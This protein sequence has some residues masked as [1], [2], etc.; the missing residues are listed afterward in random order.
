MSE[1]TKKLKDEYDFIA[2]PEDVKEK[3]ELRRFEDEFKK[4]SPI[5][6]PEPEENYEEEE[7]DEFD[8][9]SKFRDIDYGKKPPYAETRPIRKDETLKRR[10]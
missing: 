5:Y 10:E 1:T 6:N 4:Y 3:K 7:L 8:Q 2:Y 9:P